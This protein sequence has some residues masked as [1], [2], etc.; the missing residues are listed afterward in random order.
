MQKP[1]VTDRFFWLI[2]NGKSLV[3]AANG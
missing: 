3:F 1:M 2:F